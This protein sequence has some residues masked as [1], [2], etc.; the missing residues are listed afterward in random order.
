MRL[1]RLATLFWAFC[2]VA[3]FVSIYYFTE[4]I[5]RAPARE[6][7]H[8]EMKDNK[9]LHFEDKLKHL[10]SEV[11][12]YH[13]VVGELK[14]AVQEL[15]P[16]KEGHPNSPFKPSKH[17]SRK[18]QEPKET[19]N[20]VDFSEVKCSL[21][22]DS[23]PN[24]HIQMLN[25]YDK[26]KFDNP[27]GGP[28]K[29][30]WNIKYDPHQW[31]SHHKLKVFIL[32]H[33]HND[34]GWLK[35]FEEYYAAQTRSILNNALTKLSEDTRRKFIWAE[36]SFFSLWWKEISEE[37]RR[38]TKKLI[39]SGQ[40]EIVTGGW[41]MN[42]EATSH[43]LSIV[44]QLT[45]GHQWLKNNLNI[46]PKSGWAIDPFGH[47]ATQPYLLKLTGINGSLI[48][49]VHYSVK[50]ELALQKQ[51]EFRWRQIWDGIGT[52]DMWTH[53]MPFYSY[54]V[55]HS[56]GPDPKVCCQFDFKRLPGYGLSCP[57]KIAPQV[58]TER[59]VKHKA[60]LLLDQWRKKSQLYQTRVVLMPL[61][62][63]FRWD[64]S[65]EWDAQ[66]NNYEKI[67]EYLN[68]NDNLHVEARFGTLSEYFNAV[69]KEKS[70]EEFPILSGDFFTYADRDDHYWSGY[71]TSRPFY[72]RMD[73][74]L[75]SYVRAA[76]MIL[77]LARTR[78]DVPHVLL[79][80]EA[81]LSS[82]LESSRQSLALFQHHDGVT[83]TSRDPVV[84]D[85]GNK[86]LAAISACQHVIQQSAYH[87]L[88]QP[89]YY[90]PAPE[91]V[92]FEV[93]DI[94][95]E[96]SSLPEKITITVGPE[97]PSRKIVIFNSLPFT[98]NEVVSLYVSTPFLT[99]HTSD[100]QVDCQ[101]S[102]IVISG[103][104]I[105]NYKYLLSFVAIVPAMGL[106]SYIVTAVDRNSLTRATSY[107]TLRFL[108]YDGES[109][110]GGVFGTVQVVS[111]STVGDFVLSRNTGEG[112]VAAFS[113]IG[114]L[115]AIK[116]PGKQAVPVHLDFRKY[117]TRH[118]GDKSG[119]YLFLPGIESSIIN[120]TLPYP[121]ITVIEGSILSRMN[122]Q[123]P[124]VH[125]T[126]SIYSGV[127]YHI[128]VTNLVDITSAHNLEL[129]M[130]LSTNIANGDEFYTDLNGYQMI[131]RK[132][133]TKI[134]LQA[135]FYPL[136]SAAYI[137]DHN[138][139][140]T[141]L[142]STSLGVAAL[143]PGQIEVMQDRR[144]NQDDNRGMAQGVLDN[145]PTQH[146]FRILLENKNDEKC[147][148]AIQDH[149]AGQLSLSAH[150]SSE[151][152][153]NPLISLFY[154][155]DGHPDRSEPEWS[156]GLNLFDSYTPVSTEPG[157]DVIV[158]SYRDGVSS[159]MPNG[160]TKKGRG[161][162]LHRRN[163]NMCYSSDQQLK[164]YNTNDGK[165]NLSAIVPI[166][167]V[168]EVRNSSLSFLHLGSQVD[169]FSSQ[170]ICPME[171]N[172]YFIYS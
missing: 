61:G 117:G 149:P 37:Q 166:S 77:A 115:K 132:Y 158:A 154:Y 130:R 3:C 78:A 140:L 33:S 41:V 143:T 27:D 155:E 133:L 51:L 29:Q 119:G 80:P 17:Q 163:L 72:K 83:G 16:K 90:H 87:L 32:P 101:I 56:C 151:T 141:L 15:L 18:S 30:G 2:M 43:W 46:V 100:N 104:K 146:T 67:I 118:T 169:P 21:Q 54:D 10:E 159:T 65:T 47:S 64:H 99:I 40:W 71:Y 147:Q 152:L 35:T 97:A 95:R 167:E 14:S 121:M 107:A 129:V 171:I 92:Y 50:K 165:V 161:L 13:A 69:K 94:R 38:Q 62:D 73:R 110:E 76:E 120:T 58:I 106:T 9:W 170:P 109:F 24:S 135:N 98:R 68:S 172:S 103:N 81:G 19:N 153:L 111:G 91:Q 57:W 26:L 150:V 66:F 93:D 52:T 36:I 125:H 96:H 124:Y 49:R 42:D 86:L 31:N 128:E 102:P 89:K 157:V 85:Y 4:E 23:I 60:E 142:T 131:R 122:V 114:L 12:E 22:M 145:H 88:V 127:D 70:S 53:M 59:N 20:V 82:K 105:S 75:M 134:P 1:R 139:R 168:D 84:V 48:Q 6:S 138:A 113:K 156:Y 44:Q 116:L 8:E 28:W 137:E 5:L 34:P 79:T 126:V 39:Q 45:T 148:G 160:K 112:V 162:V 11:S 74:V 7:V 55:P 63:D 25:V 108:N 144:L 164:T 136:P 123:F